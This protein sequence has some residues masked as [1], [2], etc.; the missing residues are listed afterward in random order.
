MP[1]E[2]FSNKYTLTLGAACSVNLIAGLYGAN[3]QLIKAG[4]VNIDFS[5]G[6]I[7][8]GQI[9]LKMPEKT[10]GSYIQVLIWDETIGMLPMAR[11]MIFQ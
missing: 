2:G 9:K 1:A 6:N 4:I 10:E 5:D 3:N 7:Q 8:S 11:K